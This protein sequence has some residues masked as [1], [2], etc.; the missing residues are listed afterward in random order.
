M[1]G[2]QR[3]RRWTCPV[4]RVYM[5]FGSYL[6]HL[7]MGRRPHRTSA[8]SEAL[9]SAKFRSPNLITVNDWSEVPAF[10]T[11]A[12]EAEFWGTHGLSEALLDQ[13]K[14]LDDIL[15]RPRRRRR[16]R[17]LIRSSE[18]S[19]AIPTQPILSDHVEAPVIDARAWLKAS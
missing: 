10:T 2:N 4:H 12:E 8:V 17:V 15:P 9:M 19:R 13:M 16:R 11:E 6:H 5:A 7:G 3:D 18:F 1:G 14:P